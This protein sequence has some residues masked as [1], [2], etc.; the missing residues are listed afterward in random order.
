MVA[1][2]GSSAND[3]FFVLSMPTGSDSISLLHILVF[4]SVSSN[5]WL[6]TSEEHETSLS[7]TLKLLSMIDEVK[8]GSRL[9]LNS[10]FSSVIVSRPIVE[11]T[12]TYFPRAKAIVNVRPFT[13]K[14]VLYLTAA[15]RIPCV[16][17]S[18]VLGSVMAPHNFIGSNG[19][20]PLNSSYE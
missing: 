16:A 13:E 9:K 15:D 10:S 2:F 12:E 7:S 14:G 11:L 19:F 3:T 6:A 4:F 8:C 18:N 20:V 17:V 1:V 5:K